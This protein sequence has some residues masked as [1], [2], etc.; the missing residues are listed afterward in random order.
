[1]KPVDLK[2]NIEQE[3]VD[4]VKSCKIDTILTL[5]CDRIKNLLPLIPKYFKEIPVTREEE[6]M[7]LAAGLYLA[8]RKPAMLIQSTGIGNS[9]NA[10]SSLHLTYNIP[11]PI[12]ASWRGYY[13]EEIPAHKYFGE[14]LSELLKCMEIPFVTIES[15]DELPAMKYAVESAFTKLTP[16]TALISPKLWENSNIEP[17]KSAESP[18]QREYPPR[19]KSVIKSA[20]FSRFEMINGIIPYIDGKIVLS[21]IGFPSKELYAAHDQPTNFYMLGSLGLVTSIGIG[22]ALGNRKREVIV[23]DGDGSLLM[24]PNALCS[25]AQEHP[26]NLTL[27]AFD[28][29]AYGSTGCQRSF[30]SNIDLKL[31]AN[32]LGID[33]TS[34]ISTPEELL[35][36]LERKSPGPRFIHAM[37]LPKNA[38]VSN[39]PLSPTDIK[40]RF[41]KALQ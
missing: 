23:L 24:N 35:S 11:L 10:L 14:R 36:Q 28:N 32:S 15:R 21:N 19:K 20:K 1:M 30:S 31:L 12:L 5:P 3:V 16:Y 37:I 27:I 40:E 4:V 33:N 22:I 9:L 41:M 2:L 18:L 29:C 17:Y 34:I 8:G 39:V 7:G 13:K 25:L 6:G 38:R 26:E